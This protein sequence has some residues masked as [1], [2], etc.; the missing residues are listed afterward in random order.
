MS[1]QVAS[2]CSVRPACAS[3]SRRAGKGVV[4]ENRQH[5]LDVSAGRAQSA[6]EVELA[7]AVG[8]EVVD[9]QHRKSIDIAALDLRVVADAERTLA[10]VAQR[11]V[12]VCRRA[13][14]RRECRRFPRLRPRR[15]ACRQHCAHIA[16]A[17]CVTA[18][19]QCG[20]AD[21]DAAIDIDRA[22][23]ACRQNKR[24]LPA[25]MDGAALKQKP[26]ASPPISCRSPDRHGRHLAD[27]PRQCLVAAENHDLGR[28]RRRPRP[29]RGGLAPIQVIVPR[30]EFA[31]RRI[32]RRSARQRLSKRSSAP[33][34]SNTCT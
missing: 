27:R 30:V 20:F 26:R 19:R 31:G 8:G 3:R 11:H 15:Q 23:P 32:S 5:V 2:G 14:T 28:P 7:A 9:Q 33:S 13:R 21:E 1:S 4:I 6:C 34:S 12:R 24:L 10:H 17:S 22:R 16:A 18:W 29:A 25:D